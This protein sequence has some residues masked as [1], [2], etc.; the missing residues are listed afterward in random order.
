MKTNNS[1]KGLD[2]DSPQQKYS[3]LTEDDVRVIRD[4][5]FG[6]KSSDKN[7]EA[8]RENWMQTDAITWL[9]AHEGKDLLI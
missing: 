8:C 4:K 1:I 9:L 2:S 5:V 7:W 6:H 3:R